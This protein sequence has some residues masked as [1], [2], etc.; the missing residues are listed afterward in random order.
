MTGGQ[1][2]CD[3]GIKPGSITDVAGILVGH[4]DR[5]DTDATLGSGWACGTTVVVAPPGT[6]AAV[7]CR[8]GAPGSRETDL[9]DPS[10]SV[11]HV[12]AVV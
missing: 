10:H 11:R 6:T 12:D 8:G 5:I 1:E 3:R 4:H 9:L 7:D 2:R